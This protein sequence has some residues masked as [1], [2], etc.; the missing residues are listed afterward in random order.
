LRRGVGPTALAAIL[1]L[2]CAA[3]SPEAP[4]G[5]LAAVWR[6][7]RRLPEHRALAIAGDLRQTRWVSGASG[8]HA[9]QSAAEESALQECRVRR[10]RE[11][12]QAACQLYAIG[13]EIV[14]QGPR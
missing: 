5:T 9:T 12:Q 4:P 3:R 14:W 2:A 8:G 10:L 13:D 7:Y 1:A 11:R 6:D